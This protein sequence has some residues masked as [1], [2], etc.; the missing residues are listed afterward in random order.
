MPSKYPPAERVTAGRLVAGDELLIRERKSDQPFG[1][2]WHHEP[3]L[4]AGVWTVLAVSSTLTSDRRRAK[5]TYTLRLEHPGAGCRAFEASPSER[6]N[7]VTD[8]P[9]P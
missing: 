3:E 8:Y 7:R 2:F 9:T 4:P 1:V 6:F 5:R